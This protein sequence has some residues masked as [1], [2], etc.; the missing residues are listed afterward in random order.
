MTAAI[1]D[2]VQN[3]FSAW[4]TTVYIRGLSEWLKNSPRY[5]NKKTQ[6]QKKIFFQKFEDILQG[7]IEAEKK[8]V[9]SEFL[10]RLM[11]RHVN[12]MGFL[13]AIFLHMDISS[14]RKIYRH[15][16]EKLII[17]KPIF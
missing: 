15:S 1:S 13:V 5:F 4:T 16:K 3:W 6:L 2:S 10:E 9:Q 8:D 17:M 12:F 7:E 14:V 11:K